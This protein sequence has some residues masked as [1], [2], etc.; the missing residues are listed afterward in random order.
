MLAPPGVLFRGAHSL[1]SPLLEARPD[2]P[3]DEALLSS[4][5]AISTRSLWMRRPTPTSFVIETLPLVFLV[6]PVGGGTRSSRGGRHLSGKSARDSIPPP[7]SEMP[8]VVGIP[9]TISRLGERR[10]DFGMEGRKAGVGVPRATA[11][12][13]L[14]LQPKYG[15]LHAWAWIF[16]WIACSQ[17]AACCR[18]K[19]LGKVL[20]VPVGSPR[21]RQHHHHQNQAS[22]S[23]V[24]ATAGQALWS[25]SC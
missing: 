20:L 2:R 9:A 16:S 12:P 19:P 7:R 3:T 18:Q 21:W 11:T 5:F 15:I 25:F 22:G 4:S 8:R 6:A 17:L 23:G 1:G 10:S 13:P 14:S 24:K